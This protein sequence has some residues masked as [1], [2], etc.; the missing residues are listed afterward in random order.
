MLHI[1]RE[2]R[3]IYGR[4]LLAALILVVGNGTSQGASRLS[5]SAIVEKVDA[6][7]VQI[8]TDRGTGSGF[9]LNADGYIATNHHVLLG[10]SSYKVRQGNQEAPASRIW[11]NASLDLAIIR[12]SLDGLEALALAVEPPSALADVIAFG[13]PAIS[14]TFDA[15][16]RI[17][18][19]RTKGN[20]N[21]SVYWGSWGTGGERLQ[22]VEHSAQVN[23]GNSGGPLVDD[24]GRAVGINTAA[25][26][27]I[28]DGNNRAPGATGVYWS[29]F[30]VELADELDLLGISYTKAIDAC[31]P[32]TTASAGAFS[33]EI[34]DLRRQ[35]PDGWLMQAL[36]AGGAILVSAITV[37]LAFASFRR[38]VFQ[39]AAL[40]RKSATRLVSS[41]RGSSNGNSADSEGST[42]A[43]GRGMNM[44][45][46][47]TSKKVSRHH[48]ELE[49][50]QRGYRLTDKDSTNGTRVFRDGQWRQ[51][52][53]ET[54]RPYD[55]LELGDYRT[56]AAELVRVASR[57]GPGERSRPVGEHALDELPHGPVRRNARGQVVPK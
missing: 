34:E 27:V 3:S 16:G 18:P 22:I 29:A 30:I 31:E 6:S 19:T 43:I 5:D 21:R 25:P 15:P 17:E 52:A 7:V 51:I 39:V 54:V 35:D 14:G 2:G 11:A 24:C 48:A 9:A 42:I 26:L 12:T 36:L 56:T 57:P 28:L 55:Q 1:R 50:S 20:V 38:T 32:G 47:L 13:F 41:R 8:V 10:S 53:S 49:L 33:E 44:D 4:G 45:V 46:Q 23:P 40:V 37:I